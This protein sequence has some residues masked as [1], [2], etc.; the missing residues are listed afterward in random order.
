MVLSQILFS[1][2]RERSKSHL[3]CFE[4]HLFFPLFFSECYRADANLPVCPTILLH[5]IKF[6]P[7]FSDT[8]LIWDTL[9]YS[10]CFHRCVRN[11]LI[12]FWSFKI[13]V[14][15]H[16]Q[17]HFLMVGSRRILFVLL[18]NSSHQWKFQ[19]KHLSFFVM[20][21]GMS[22]NKVQS[23]NFVVKENYVFTVQAN[24]IVNQ[25]TIKLKKEDFLFYF[26]SIVYWF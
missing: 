2:S 23:Y 26:L 10:V 3:K 19:V 18:Q 13:S 24:E 12:T 16:E 11:G 4:V 1:H 6:L 15:L 22:I 21:I 7:S 20:Q 17:F 9:Q 14:N 8:P 25:E 5:I